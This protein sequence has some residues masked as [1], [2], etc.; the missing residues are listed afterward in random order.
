MTH[1]SQEFEQ[2]SGAALPPETGRP[3]IR[4]PNYVSLIEFLPHAA[5]DQN[6]A[7][8]AAGFK[9]TTRQIVFGVIR[10][11]TYYV[12]SFHISLLPTCVHSAP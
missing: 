5:G 8:A 12:A 1:A 6:E 11:C 4:K 10:N 9:E 3:L 2:G 7:Q